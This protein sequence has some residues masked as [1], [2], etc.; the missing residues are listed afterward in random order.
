MSILSYH[1]YLLTIIQVIS[2]SYVG[3]FQTICTTHSDRLCSPFSFCVFF[4]F[5]T[6]VQINFIQ[7]YS[8]WHQPNHPLSFP[9]LSLIT[10]PR[11]PTREGSTPNT[12][13]PSRGI[14]P[15]LSHHHHVHHIYAPVVPSAAVC[16]KLLATAYEIAFS[17]WI[18]E[19]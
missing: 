3:Y 18:F 12:S 7:Q 13:L 9:P 4:C 14:F 15:H 5:E 17:A 8:I 10:L 19:K 16:S 1:I 6:G 2:T 11:K